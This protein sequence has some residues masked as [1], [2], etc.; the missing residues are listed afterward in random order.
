MT[1]N[2][3]SKLLRAGLFLAATLLA[4]QPGAQ[5]E[6]IR[7]AGSG[8]SLAEVVG[9]LFDKPFTA[10]TGITVVPLATT[11]RLSALRAQML[12]GN[13]TWDVTELSGFDYTAASKQGWL[14]PLDWEKIDPHNLIAKEV[15]Y[16][17]A[18]PYTAFSHLLGYRT[19]KAPPGR[20][21]TSWA[22]FWDVKAFPGP[23]GM[24]DGPNYN[25]E[26]ALLADGVPKDKLYEVLRTPAGVDRAFRKMDAIKDS[27]VL[28]W[29]SNGQAQQALSD[30]EV[31]YVTNANGRFKVAAD[32]GLPV[33]IVWNGGAALLG[34]WGVVKGTKHQEAAMK[35][36]SFF[37]GSPQRAADF[38][39]AIAYPM[40]VKGTLDLLTPAQQAS[41]PTYPANRVGQFT[42]D[43]A[44]WVEN[45]AKINQ[46]WLE[47][48]LR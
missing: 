1:R 43:D 5:A 11:D 30:G 27:V 29:K 38:T 12:A 3:K 36:L 8:G 15:R 47:W 45:S 23:R 17:D 9:R 10:E 41:L 25:L 7:V 44:F 16:P 2:P 40:L 4:F 35:Y 42:Y 28:W 13:T 20:E 46:R 33:K 19:D 14:L 6:E 37:V 21:V 18:I 24:F 22:D 48:K 34:Y 31:Y 32:Q 39:K 26:F